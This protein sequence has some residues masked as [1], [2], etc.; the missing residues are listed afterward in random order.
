MNFCLQHNRRSTLSRIWGKLKQGLLH[1]IHISMQN[2]K[3]RTEFQTWRNQALMFSVYLSDRKDWNVEQHKKILGNEN[4]RDVLFESLWARFAPHVFEKL[5]H[6]CCSHESSTQ[7]RRV[8]TEMQVS[9]S[10]NKQ[11]SPTHDISVP[12][13]EN[14]AD[15][16][17]E[18]SRDFP[19][20]PN[21][22]LKSHK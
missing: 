15:T 3:F 8:S 10:S 22:R 2:Q 9:K 1:V 16:I 19:S 14:R 13:N 18:S 12:G 21:S 7:T 20:F 11:F 6:W 4:V 5:G 17:V